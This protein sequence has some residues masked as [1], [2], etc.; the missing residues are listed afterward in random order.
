[1]PY[2]DFDGHVSP[3]NARGAVAPFFVSTGSFFASNASFRHSGQARKIT[4]NGRAKA[5]RCRCRGL[6]RSLPLACRLPS[7]CDL[8][9]GSVAPRLPL[10]Y[11]LRQCSRRRE[12]RRV[13]KHE[14]IQL[15]PVRLWKNPSCVRHESGRSRLVE[16]EAQ[17][18]HF[19]SLAVRCS[20][21]WLSCW[22]VRLKRA[23]RSC[24]WCSCYE[25]GKRR[26]K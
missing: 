8:H 7:G 25:R 20:L 4:R 3:V 16:R 17:A 15:K 5:A 6:L 2:S 23:I 13:G 22:R 9:Q 11:H 10:P 24:R 14:A 26:G 19:L 18:R 21:P 1:M 12:L